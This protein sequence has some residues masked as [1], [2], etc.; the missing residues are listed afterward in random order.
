[1]IGLV[2]AIGLPPAPVGLVAEAVLV[3]ASGVVGALATV[4]VGVSL[5]EFLRLSRGTGGSAGWSILADN[6]SKRLVLFLGVVSLSKF[7]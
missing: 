4:K 7:S 1:M 6:A 2:S 5:V 3:F